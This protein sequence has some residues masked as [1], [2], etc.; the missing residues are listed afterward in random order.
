M[1]GASRR[2]GREFV[3]EP[4]SDIER[5]ISF[6][7]GRPF[8]ESQG[9]WQT[10]LHPGLEL[11]VVLK[12]VERIHY[13]GHRL[14]CHPGDVW[15]CGMWEW[16]STHSDTPDTE[17]AVWTFLPQS[18]SP[19]S[20]GDLSPTTMFF[21]A[22]EHRPRLATTRAKKRALAIVC[23]AVDEVRDERSL[24]DL[25]VRFYLYLMLC[26]LLRNWNQDARQEAETIRA[27]ASGALERVMPAIEAVNRS[28]GK[29][30]SRSAAAGA[31]MLSVP[32]F[33][34]LFRRA[35]G[36]SF[37]QFCLHSRLGVAAHY[38]VTSDLAV[39]QIAEITDFSDASHLHRH[40]VKT[41]GLTPARYRRQRH[42]YSPSARASLMTSLVPQDPLASELPPE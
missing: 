38:L 26:K 10:H 13:R 12:G 18:L 19:D 39:A 30:V 5:P 16:H 34:A 37:S 24:R 22:S 20:W 36:S 21:V 35:T 4:P 41:Y 9:T 8:P 3:L 17:I 42:A 28:E 6:W 11:G 33:Q 15:L 29:R 25:S 27:S 31:C 40:F 2:R 1:R 32:H 23:A 14:A 7:T